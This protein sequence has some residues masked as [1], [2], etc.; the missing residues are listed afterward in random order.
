MAL[1]DYK[2]TNVFIY[3]NANMGIYFGQILH[4]LYCMRKLELHNKRKLEAQSLVLQVI[5]LALSFWALSL[6]WD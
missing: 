2:F 5:P 1:L 6:I 4:N 3:L